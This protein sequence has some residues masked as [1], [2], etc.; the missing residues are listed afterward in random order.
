MSKLVR[1]E[2][3]SVRYGREMALQNIDLDIASGE[4]LAVIGESG[5][6][7]S[8]LALALASLLPAGAHVTGGMEWAAGRLQP[9]RDIGF[10]FQDP[11]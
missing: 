10:I 6:G 3:L 11:A 9:G 1:L 2:K 7:K 8:T 4:I 5:S